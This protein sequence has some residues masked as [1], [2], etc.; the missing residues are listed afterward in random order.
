MEIRNSGERDLAAAAPE[1]EQQHAATGSRLGAGNAE[2]DQTAFFE[3]GDDFHVPAG[4]GLHP[5]LKSGGVTRVAHGGGGH[6]TNA[7]NATCLHGALKTLERAQRG[8]HG[9]RRDEAGVKDAA[10]EARDLAIFGERFEPMRV[11]AGDLESARVGTDVDGSEGGHL[12][13]ARSVRK[14]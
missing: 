4:L 5:G 7:V 12:F 6:H 10:T 3:A 1:V 9:L 8:R 13:A 14:N 2:M 11:D